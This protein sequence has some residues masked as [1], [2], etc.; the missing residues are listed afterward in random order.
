MISEN[1]PREEWSWQLAFRDR[2]TTRPG[3][4]HARRRSAT[5][6][7]VRW[8]PPVLEGGGPLDQ[9]VMVVGL[10]DHETGGQQTLGAVVQAD[11]AGVLIG[12]QASQPIHERP[13]GQGADEG[14]APRGHRDA[15][16][17]LELAQGQRGGGQPYRLLARGG[18][19][20]GGEQPT[21]DQ[22]IQA[23]V[24]GLEQVADLGQ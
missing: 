17:W 6:G 7:R 10:A 4:G 8:A 11:G 15:R 16:R 1:C 13:Y 5:G 12:Q 14:G 20:R 3:R 2:G 24:E 22:A 21:I 19:V 23:A 18:D 9:V